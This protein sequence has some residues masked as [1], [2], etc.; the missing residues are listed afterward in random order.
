MGCP[1]SEVMPGICARFWRTSSM[2]SAWR[3]F[4][5]RVTTSISLALTPAACSS[6]S[7][8]PVLRVVETTSG[9]RWR[10]SS[11]IRPMRLDSCKEVPGGNDI[12]IFNAPSLKGG[13]RRNIGKCKRGKHP[14]F[15]TA[16]V[17]QRHEHENDDQSRKN[18]RTTNFA[19]G[20]KDYGLRCLRHA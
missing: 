10:V 1:T 19:R 17:E 2:T 20:L 13:N 12:L 8:R 6:S 4:S 14:A 5:G 9:V 16:E 18:D 15:E 11:T 7:A 3:R